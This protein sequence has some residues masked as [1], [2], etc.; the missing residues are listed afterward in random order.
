MNPRIKTVQPLDNYRLLLTFKNGEEKIFDVKPWLE[1][2][3]YLPLKSAEY[4]KKA[5]T[6]FGTVSW[7]KDIDF[8]PDILY[9][10]SK[11]FKSFF[12]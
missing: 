5:H 1:K 2:P 3:V 4:F 7:G 11:K 10:E 9:L 6:A 8:C 12:F